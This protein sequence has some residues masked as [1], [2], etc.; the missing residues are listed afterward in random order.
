MTVRN[1][2]SSFGEAMKSA[3]CQPK[4][5]ELYACGIINRKPT[6]ERMLKGFP[7]R[8][9]QVTAAIGQTHAREIKRA[10]EQFVK[11]GRCQGSCD[12]TN[13]KT[14]FNLFQSAAK[15]NAMLLDLETEAR[16]AG[17]CETCLHRKHDAGMC[18]M[19]GCGQTEVIGA[20]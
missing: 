7:A 11:V 9:A 8:L 6:V 4:R 3:E 14:F 18:Q 10:V 12:R 13:G 2:Q 17:E 15:L 19:C 16:Y 1:R 5:N 20:Y